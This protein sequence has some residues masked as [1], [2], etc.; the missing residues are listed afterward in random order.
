MD[1]LAASLGLPALDARAD[2]RL[3]AALAALPK[4]ARRPLL[5]SYLGFPFYD[6]ATLPLLQGE[7]LD[8]FD[9]VRSIAF[10]PMT[11]DRS[12]RAARRRR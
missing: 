8:E 2:E 3:A 12:A 11:A 7:G 6:V 10:R 9:P 1:A 4:E 5:L